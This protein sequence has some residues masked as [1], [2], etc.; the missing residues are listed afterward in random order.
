VFIPVHSCI[1]RILKQFEVRQLQ[2]LMMTLSAAQEY[3]QEI[4]G[5]V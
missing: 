5:S 1:R 4:G 2:L 3:A